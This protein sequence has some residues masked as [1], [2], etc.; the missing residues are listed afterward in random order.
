MDECQRWW[1]SRA[2]GGGATG[3][4]ASAA[5]SR[6]Q[7]AGR[8]EGG[9]SASS[10][11]AHEGT[12]K[13]RTTRRAEALSVLEALI[14]K[15]WES[16][17]H[18]ARTT[19][20]TVSLVVAELAEPEAALPPEDAPIAAGLLRSVPPRVPVSYSV[21]ATAI[22]ASPRRPRSSFGIGSGRV[23]RCGERRRFDPS[24]CGCAPVK[25]M[26]SGQ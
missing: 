14:G 2:G 25:G 15:A 1:R 24:L 3:Y 19:T 11:S 5:P 20:A 9:G 12:K 4:C 23:R 8:R 22:A 16:I 17:S 13:I 6:C 21:S 10:R 7:F 26:P 18:Q